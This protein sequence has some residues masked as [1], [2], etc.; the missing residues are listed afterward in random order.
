MSYK[1]TSP[2]HVGDTILYHLSRT[3]PIFWKTSS[4]WWDS[5]SAHGNH[6]KSL[7]IYHPLSIKCVKLK[8]N[9][10]SY[11]ISSANRKSMEKT[12]KSRKSLK[13][14]HPHHPHHRFR[15]FFFPPVLIHLPL[16]RHGRTNP[17]QS[18]VLCWSYHPSTWPAGKSMEIACGFQ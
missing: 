2:N 14:H 1:W 11:P 12:L 10:G 16:V 9:D 5:P 8:Q 4:Q 17:S 15:G 6:W 7:N 3:S 18:Q 13:P